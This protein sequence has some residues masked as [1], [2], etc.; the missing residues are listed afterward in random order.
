MLPD[1]LR[2]LIDESRTRAPYY[3]NRMITFELTDAATET[4]AR[5]I[6]NH[7]NAEIT[8]KKLRVG[9][10]GS[11]GKEFFVTPDQP[12]W[13][14][15]RNAEMGKAKSV[16]ATEIAEWHAAQCHFDWASG[17]IF[18]RR[19]REGVAVESMAG[20]WTRQ[21]G[22][23]FDQNGLQKIFPNLDF[24]QLEAAWALEA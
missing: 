16:M 2:G 5:E 9:P 11:P 8:A 3:K 6:C 12:P 22:W 4:S 14:R 1:P 23:R 17:A 24:S 10:S 20:R 19:L 18:L 15:A 21:K 7:L 13:K